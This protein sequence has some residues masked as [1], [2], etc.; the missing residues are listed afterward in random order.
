V[1]V[2]LYTPLRELSG[3]ERTEVVQRWLDTV[4]RDLPGLHRAVW[5]RVQTLIPPSNRG[6]GAPPAVC[7]GV[8]PSIAQAVSRERHDQ[9]F[10]TIVE[11]TVT[12]REPD[13][14]AAQGK[15]I[16][17]IDDADVERVAQL[18]DDQLL[19]V[20]EQTIGVDVRGAVQQTADQ[21]ASSG[22]TM[23]QLFAVHRRLDLQRVGQYQQA[24]AARLQALQV[25]AAPPFPASRDE[26]IAR[27]AMR[28][29]GCI[30]FRCRVGLSQDIARRAHAIHHNRGS[31]LVEDVVYARGGAESLWSLFI[32]WARDMHA[33]GDVGD[34]T[35]LPARDDYCQLCQQ[36]KE[37][38]VEPI[39]VELPPELFT[40]MGSVKACSAACATAFIMRHD[41][42]RDRPGP[43]TQ[44]QRDQVE[45]DLELARNRVA[46][47]ATKDEARQRKPLHNPWQPWE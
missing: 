46:I 12:V 5:D 8:A 27:E 36:P 38:D 45:Y 21:S 2:S 20:V 19:A 17:Q 7:F 4:Q 15:L 6:Y 32:S 47:A 24:Y 40:Q 13:A 39:E 34:P 41:L 14:S 11:H 33:A 43:R 16:S 25:M 44:R 1:A 23:Q 18:L 9:A 10:T 30:D 37:P 42:A 29:A 26:Q 3:A 28:L 22:F 35:R 31:M